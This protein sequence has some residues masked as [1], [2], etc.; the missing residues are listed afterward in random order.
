MVAL[1]SVV[2]AWLQNPGRVTAGE[3][4]TAAE[5]AFASAGLRGAAVDDTPELDVFRGDDDDAA[6]TVWKTRAELDAGTVELWLA[7]SDG[8]L[9]FLD[10]RN[11]D[12][13]S[14][15][16]TDA[17]FKR[18]Q[19]HDENPA[20]PRKVRRNIALSVA[21]LLVAGMGWWLSAWITN[22]VAPAPPVS[23]TTPR[24]APRRPRTRQLRATEE[25]T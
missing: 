4:V 23:A 12:G 24:P 15:L 5:K 8:S 20:V 17:E 18:L 13:S 22:A 11:A 6:I 3:A 2:L 16:L 7:R 10:D 1:A 25:M 14:Q 19:D 9:V 21:A